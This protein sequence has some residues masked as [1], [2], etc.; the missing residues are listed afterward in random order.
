MA[1]ALRSPA[2]NRFY[3]GRP[4]KSSGVIRIEEQIV[5]A[6]TWMLV[7]ANGN[8]GEALRVG[9]QLDREGNTATCE[10]GKGVWHRLPV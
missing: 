10:G 7:Q 1:K 9:R 8:V 4:N 5:G 3:L 2:K 6:K